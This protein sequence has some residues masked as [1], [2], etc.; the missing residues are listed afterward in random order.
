MPS[1]GAPTMKRAGGSGTRLG[2]LNLRRAARVSFLNLHAWARS[3]STHPLGSRVI[4]GT[5][6]PLGL[7]P[8]PSWCAWRLR[9]RSIARS[10]ARTIVTCTKSRASTH[11]SPP[12]V[13]A[14]KI[15]RR[16]SADYILRGSPTQRRQPRD[17]K[18]KDGRKEDYVF[19]ARGRQPCSLESMYSS[20]LQG[21]GVG[22]GCAADRRRG[23]LACISGAFAGLSFRLPLQTDL[24]GDRRGRSIGRGFDTAYRDACT[25]GTH[26]EKWGI[27]RRALPLSHNICFPTRIPIKSSFWPYLRICISVVLQRNCLSC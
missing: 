17:L 14:R 7:G 16:Y 21:G 4:C 6:A 24:R 27:D 25:I 15:R 13:G 12:A 11:S 20:T 5:A 8:Q 3:P 19:Q 2:T 1:A 9:T 22:S 23:A 10:L 18:N 26:F